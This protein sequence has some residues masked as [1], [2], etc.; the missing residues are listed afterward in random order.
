MTWTG[1]NWKPEPHKK[2]KSRRRREWQKERDRVREQ[3]WEM[4][5]RCCVECGKPVVLKM[6]EGDWWNV[7]NINEIKPRSL[8]GD[9]LDLANLNTKCGGCHTGKGYHAHD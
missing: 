5:D 9:P 8:G 1:P 3:R 7:A 4:D 2:V 6:A